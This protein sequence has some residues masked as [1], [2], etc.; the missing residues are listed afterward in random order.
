MQ[1]AKIG[2]HI[3]QQIKQVLTFLFAFAM[4]IGDM[5]YEAKYKSLLLFWYLGQFVEDVLYMLVCLVL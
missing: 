5:K 1:P 3:I 2:G 4:C